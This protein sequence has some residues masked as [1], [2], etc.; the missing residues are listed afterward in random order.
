MTKKTITVTLT[1]N[2]KIP[3]QSE[4]I[5]DERKHPTRVA[6]RAKERELLPLDQLARELGVHLR[7]LRAAART[8]RLDAHFSVRSV[9][10]RPIRFASRAAGQRFLATHYRQL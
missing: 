4:R 2:A 10:G 8:G 6:A 9:F 7:T 1:V 5:A 3:Q